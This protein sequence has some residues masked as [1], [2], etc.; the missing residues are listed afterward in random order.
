MESRGHLRNAR[1]QSIDPVLLTATVL[2]VSLGIVMV[3]SASTSVSINR[4]G[5][6]Y[7]YLIRQVIWAALGTVAM[8]VT[9]NIPYWRWQK[10]AKPLFILTVFLLIIVL[11]PHVGIERKGARRWL[12]FEPFVFQPSEVAKFTLALYLAAVVSRKN[13]KVRSFMH[14]LLPLL[15]AAGAVVGLVIIEDMGTSLAIAGV[16]AFV[17]F[18]AGANLFQ[19]T[20]IASVAALGVVALAKLDQYR[21]DRLT[22]FLNPWKDPTGDG[23]QIIQ[24]LFA[25]APGGLLGRGLAGSRQKRFFLPEPQTDFIF[26]I[27]AE[28]L[29]FVGALVLLV[30]FLVFAWR[31]LRTAMQAPDTFGML[32]AVGLTAQVIVQALLNIAV[33]TGSV[34]LTGVPLP[35]I[36]YGGSSLLMTMASIG[37]LLNISKYAKER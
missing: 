30:L 23:Y 4:Y 13:F 35:L 31:G 8:L 2:I 36:S 28:E 26:A 20:G 24:S 11:I 19:L 27:T 33:V 9:S 1:K 10:F 37:V 22:I 32:F 7:F 14:G 6:P 29:G 12:G 17:L 5:H 16:A 15:V 34:P 3:F 21:W 25:I 18:A